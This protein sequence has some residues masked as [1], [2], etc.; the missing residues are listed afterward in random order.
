MNTAIAG[1]G[2]FVLV[3]GWPASGKSTLARALARQL[4]VPLLVKD[5]IKESL[6]AAL[7]PPRD[8]AHS[9]DLGR[10]AVHVLLGVARRCPAAV[11]DSTWYDYARPLIA[12]LPGPLV[13]V[14][15]HVP[16]EVARRR[17][18]DRAGRRHPGHLD[19]ERTE[20]EL[21]GRPVE[22]LGV[23]PLIDVDTVS[24]V[25]VVG[26]AERIRRLGHQVPHR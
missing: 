18:R 25:D 19:L 11:L 14:R 6:I 13:E 10:A 4:D 12:E 1:T 7:G 20:D 5:E 23:G 8:V 17:Y 16:L 3:G 9:R 24:V 26:L 15:C 21:W 22:P 2:P